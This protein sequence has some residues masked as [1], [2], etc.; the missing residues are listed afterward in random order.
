M[1]EANEAKIAFYDEARATVDALPMGGIALLRS[2][3]G[4]LVV[5][6]ALGTVVGLPVAQFFQAVQR[7]AQPLKG[8]DKAVAVGFDARGIL[9]ILAPEVDLPPK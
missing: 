9:A 6:A 2:D 7:A 4:R 3:G 8:T 1:A 5:Q